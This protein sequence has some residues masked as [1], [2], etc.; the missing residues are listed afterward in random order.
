ML[1]A[2]SA[3][4]LAFS[5]SSS[6]PHHLTGN[7][8]RAHSSINIV[9]FERG[10]AQP[11]AVIALQRCRVAAFDDTPASLDDEQIEALFREFDTSNDGFIEIGELEAALSKAGKSVTREAAQDIFRRVD[12]NGDGLISLDE[13]KSV[14]KLAP[15]AVPDA[16][17]ALTGVSSFFLDGLGLV[18]D[19]LGI[20][21]KQWRT[22]DQ[23]SRYVDDV[24]GS[25]ALV[26]PGDIIRMH[27]TMTLLSNDQ[28]VEGTRNGP[29][30]TFQ[31]G[32]A[33]EEGW[34]DAV[35]GM[36][37]GGQRR[38]YV[39]P[40]EGDGPTARYDIEIVGLEEGSPRS[41]QESI[42]TSLGGRRAAF[43]L[44]FAASFIPYFLPNDVKPAF[45]QAGWG[46]PERL[47]E[48]G[49]TKVD[50]VDGYVAQQLDNIFA[51]EQRPNGSP[52][53]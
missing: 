17:K 8:V 10:H 52:K 14:F 53:R 35:S 49:S 37:V 27:Y 34:N 1:F 36:R 18:G 13:F 50:K 32:E 42:I 30:R 6:A 40:S 2:I 51:Q 33:S 31:V 20:E 26:V 7:T 29:P 45:F 9:A 23:G 24:L 22:T 47:S 16:L 38:L 15:G 21:T 25:G 41:A 3:A 19:A 48:S 11:R 5:P 28:V 39:K 12:T 46:E 44:L 43:R 4:F